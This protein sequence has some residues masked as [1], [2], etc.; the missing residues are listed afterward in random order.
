MTGAWNVGAVVAWVAG[1]RGFALA[2]GATLTVGAALA[3]GATLTV[4]AA[5]ADSTAEGGGAAASGGDALTSTGGPPYISTVSRWQA[6]MPG[7][8]AMAKSAARDARPSELERGSTT[9]APQNG[10]LAPRT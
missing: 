7:V 9:R 1:V 2:V 5:L 6:T 10:Q 3:V 8:A 4:G